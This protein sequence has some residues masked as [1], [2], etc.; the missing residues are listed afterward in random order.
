MEEVQS[1]HKHVCRYLLCEAHS[2]SVRPAARALTPQAL[3]GLEIRKRQGEQVSAYLVRGIRTQAGRSTNA[4]ADITAE[5]RPGTPDK[6]KQREPVRRRVELLLPRVAP[7]GG[8]I[9]RLGL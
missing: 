3:K 9:T 7:V 2:Q 5:P 4:A 6:P 1:K 8:R